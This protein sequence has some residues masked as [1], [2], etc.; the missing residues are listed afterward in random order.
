[1]WDTL[2]TRGVCEVCMGQDE[3]INPLTG[4]CLQFWYLFEEN[5]RSSTRAHSFIF[6]IVI[7]G[8]VLFDHISEGKWMI[9]LSHFPSSVILYS[10]GNKGLKA[11]I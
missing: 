8:E 7:I 3:N 9:Y 11:C 2:T 5:C 1:M 10:G 6:Q 4:L